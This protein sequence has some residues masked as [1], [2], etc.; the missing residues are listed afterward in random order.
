MRLDELIAG[1]EIRHVGGGA[2]AGVD[3]A[4]LTEDSRTV[5]P[6]S[7]FIARSGGKADGK[8]FIAHAIA[9]GAVGVLTDDASIAAGLSVPVLFADDVPLACARLAERFFGEPSRS[10]GVLGVTGTNGKT[11][12]TYLAWQLLN[13]AGRRCGLV[14]T[15]QVDDGRGVRPATMTT[16]PALAVSRA[17][18]SMRAAGYE[19]ASMEVSSHALDQRRCDALRLKVAVF[20]N[21]TGDHL[22]YHGTMERYADA[23]ARLFALLPPDGVGIVNAD[24][25]WSERV[26]K[27]CRGPVL[28]CTTRGRRRAACTVEIVSAD[29]RGM[30]LAMMGPWG[31]VNVAVPLIG[32]YNAMNILQATAAAFAL[33]M[34]PLS[35]AMGLHRISAP[36]GRLQRVG[37]A[38]DEVTVY[39]D[40]AHSDDSLRNVLSTVRAA[41]GDRGR[42]WAVFGCGGNRDT[43]KRPRMGRAGSDLADVA[44]VTSD[45]P[46][47][48]QP[49]AIIDEVLTGVRPERRECVVVEAD[50]RKAI[51]LAVEGAEAGDVVVIAGKG[52]ETEQ[53]LPDGKGGTL[54]THFDDCEEAAA[55]L[56][57]RRT[58]RRAGAA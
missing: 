33:G 49:G 35:L 18:A 27:A 29:M 58:A 39:V 7:L 37:D 42:L 36:P 41:M 48:E 3:V 44:V 51:S 52:H 6:G 32:A 24:D 23:K 43:T 5:V 8:A 20:T 54:R 34:D 26:A 50:R 19:A 56:A 28:T 22:D 15:V 10:L 31:G 55:A 4:D 11:T 53:I 30:R 2:T 38:A 16:P 1:L 21:L 46:R 9:G 17:L 57:K 12:T 47:L 40:Y 25:P 14:G 13:G 45:N